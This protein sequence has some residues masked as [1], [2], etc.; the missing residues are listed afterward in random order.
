MEAGT[1]TAEEKQGKKVKPCVKMSLSGLKVENLPQSSVIVRVTDDGKSAEFDLSAIRKKLSSYADEIE[2]HL[3]VT[4]SDA[5][6]FQARHRMGT[7]K[8]IENN[9]RIPIPDRLPPKG[10]RFEL[11]MV[12]EAN[13]GRIRGTC[14]DLRL[15]QLTEGSLLCLAVDMD[16]GGIP[17]TLRYPVGDYPRL[18]LS[19]DLL[20][21]AGDQTVDEY[22]SL[23]DNQVK[24]FLPAVHRVLSHIA[25]KM[26]M[27]GR[28][29]LTS[30]EENWVVAFEK[31]G[32]PPE[33]SDEPATMAVMEKEEDWVY[34]VV[35]QW[36]KGTRFMEGFVRR[37]E[38]QC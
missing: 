36:A 23:L 29:E 15:P 25:R 8:D 26:G 9:I 13:Y 3:I 21:A 12:D 38:K 11:R 32:A 4:H 30:E 2:V 31:Y 34:C 14:K 35:S 6:R 28:E 10:L 16:L 19:S 24:I 1:A 18:V 37:G 7:W 22:M 20:K 27:E 5:D 17:Y 33:E